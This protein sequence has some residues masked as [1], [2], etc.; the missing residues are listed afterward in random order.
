[1][2]VFVVEVKTFE[3]ILKTIKKADIPSKL[4]HKASFISRCQKL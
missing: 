3:C 1:M 2:R 4:L